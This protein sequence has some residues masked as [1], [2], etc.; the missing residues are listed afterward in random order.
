VIVNGEKKMSEVELNGNIEVNGDEPKIEVAIATQKEIEV[1]DYIRES[2]D[3]VAH[4]EGF[5]DY[6]LIFD[7]GSNVGDGFVG[8]ILKVIIKER[9]SKKS[10]QVLAKIPPQNKQRRDVMKSMP[11]FERE[12]FVYNNLLPEFVEMQKEKRISHS[13][14][15]FNFPKTYLADYDAERDDSIII[16]ED[17]RETGHNMWNKSK[18]VNLE[19]AKLLMTALGRFHALSFAMKAR[20][21]EAFEKYKAL[22]DFVAA[23]F[24]DEGF[25]MFLNQTLSKT[26]ETLHPEDIKSRAKFQRLSEMARDLMAETTNPE[27]IDPYGVIIHGDCWVNNYLYHYKKGNL[28][29]DIVLIDWQISRY[30]TPVVDLVYFIF[31]CT[32]RQ[33]RQK[34]FDELISTYHNSLRELLDHLGGDTT[35]QFPFTALLRHLKKFGKFGVIMAA[36]ILPML[37]TKKEDMPDMDFMAENID[38][39][40]QSMVDAILDQLRKQVD[41]VGARTRDVIHDAIQYGYL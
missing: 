21:P 15:F 29:D 39:R 36:F 41:V 6:E 17:M 4:A 40:D 7:H 33:L 22:P 34:H 9:T 3:K 26:L 35:R 12:V 31:A 18:P 2:L 37:S 19:H 1:T 30:C 28:P 10:L 32:D 8:I 23:N 25:L 27:V 24:Q 11:L 13:D 5:Q 38:K 20:K 14:G 16:M